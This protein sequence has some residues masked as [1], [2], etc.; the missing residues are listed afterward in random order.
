[1]PVGF[2]IFFIIVA[3]LCVAGFAFTFAIML[4]PK[5]K[6]KIMGKQIEAG[7]YMV[8]E[9]KDDFK[10]I[11]DNI[12]D[13]TKGATKTTVRAIKEGF[14]DTVFCKHCG[15]EIEADSKFCKVCGKK[16]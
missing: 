5:F 3:I 13:A 6:A 9:H 8:E 16:Q 1:M 2:I 14:K 11:S 15:A 7:R 12:A 10:S 4:S